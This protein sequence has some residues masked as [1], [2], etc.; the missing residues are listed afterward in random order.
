MFAEETIWHFWLAVPLALTAVAIVVG[1]VALYFF[2]VV[3][4]RYP[5]DT[6]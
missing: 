1:I 5:K 6:A 2:K 3:R 4:T